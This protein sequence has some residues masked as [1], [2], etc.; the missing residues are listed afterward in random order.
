MGG[1]IGFTCID[2]TTSSPSPGSTK[3]TLS[4]EKI[5]F[6]FSLQIAAIKVI[7]KDFCLFVLAMCIVSKW[8]QSNCKM[9][10]APTYSII[11][12]CKLMPNLWEGNKMHFQITPSPMHILEPALP[13]PL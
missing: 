9:I 1:R 2:R 13:C 3:F 7:Q 8:N 10:K 4:E 5:I 6:S 12:P 11:H